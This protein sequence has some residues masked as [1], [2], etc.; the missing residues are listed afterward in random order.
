MMKAFA[1]ALMLACA[2]AAGLVSSGLHFTAGASQRRAAEEALIPLEGLD[3]V[4]LVRGKEAQGD[5]KFSVT[6]GR[7]RY[8]FAGAETRAAFE[9][10]PERYEI[11]LGGTCARMGPGTQG[12]PDLYWVYKGRI[13]L[14]GSPA[15]VAAFKAA[16]ES[17]LEPDPAPVLKTASAESVRKGR[18]LLEKA[19]EAAGGAARLDALRSYQ[20]QATTARHTQQGVAEM[21]TAL[22]VV[23]P[24]K[25]RQERAFPFGTIANVVSA[26]DGFYVMPRGAGDMIAEQRAAFESQLKRT[27]LA[28]LRARKAEGFAAAAT[29]AARSGET[30]VEQVAVSHDGVNAVLGIDAATGRVH[31]LSYRGRGPGGAYGEI[32]Q[33]FSDFRAVEG[34]TLPFKTAATFEGEAEPA[35]SSIVESVTIN[36]AVPPALFERP[37]PATARQ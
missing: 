3:P 24:D 7:F 29:G 33:T 34:L 31:T 32:V 8:L 4:L 18:A 36:A 17:F 2:G 9:K 16:P 15:C 6:R 28:V 11:Q 21:K 27:L 12:D 37:K 35:L 14:F 5:V 26:G 10:E 22:Y 13:Y 1:F 23:Y 20:E 30:N 19:V 25:A